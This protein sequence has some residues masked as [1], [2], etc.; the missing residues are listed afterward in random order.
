[1][2][3]LPSIKREYL[4]K[5]AKNGKR[6]DGRALD[7][8][9]K[10]EIEPGI[11]SKAEG[12]AKVKI[13]NTQVLAGVKM[14]IGDPYPDIPEEGIMTTAAELI[15][16]ASPDFE[17]GPPK[18]DAVELARVVDR[19]IRES[20]VIQVDKLCIEPHEKVWMIFIDIH[21]LD[22]DGNLFDAASLASLTALYNTLVPIERLRP[23]L[24]KLQEKY[25][26][27]KKYLEEHPKDYKLPLSDPPISCTSVKF[28]GV[29]AMDPCLDEEETAEARLTVATDKNGHIRAMQKGLNGSF[30]YEEVKKVIK[31]SLD[32]G[33][34]IRELLYKSIGN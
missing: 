17:A 21:I 19:G 4:M 20:E 29:V 1:M 34:K 16:L 12:S 23:T 11:I 32:N 10:I 18:E 24:E 13:G 22:H 9:R 15:P 26:S 14:D 28:N 5:L 3:I 25:P 30:T 8:Y 33:K 2:T 6:V 31:A 7:E 27:I